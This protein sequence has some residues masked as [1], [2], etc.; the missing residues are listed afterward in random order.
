MII[1]IEFNG[2]FQ[3][4]TIKIEYVLADAILSSEILCCAQHNKSYVA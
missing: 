3:S 1:T 2:E 4:R